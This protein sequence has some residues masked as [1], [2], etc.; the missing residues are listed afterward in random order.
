M[1]ASIGITPAVLALVAAFASLG[2]PSKPSGD[3]AAAASSNGTAAAAA[4]QPTA[5]PGT[6]SAPAGSGAT[7]AAKKHHHHHH[8][9]APDA[10][11]AAPPSPLDA[12]IVYEPYVNKTNCYKLDIP[13]GMVLESQTDAGAGWKSTEGSVEIHV[14][15]VPVQDAPDI[16]S[17][18]AADSQDEPAE[19]RRVTL[20]VKEKTFYVVSGFEGSNIFYEKVMYPNLQITFEVS[21]PAGVKEWWNRAT[22]H[23]SK[24]FVSTC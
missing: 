16:D 13:K 15:A 23:M 20:K 6:A 2:C 8:P 17:A 14:F 22:D 10:A 4:T 19:Q 9:G 1:R 24:S 12:P 5:A 21:Y 3:A 18:F 11:A 7:A